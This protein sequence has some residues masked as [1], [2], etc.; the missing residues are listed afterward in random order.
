MELH[1]QAHILRNCVRDEMEADMQ[2]LPGK[3]LNKT[4]LS[5][6]LANHTSG[7]SESLLSVIHTV[8]SITAS[9]PQAAIVVC[10]NLILTLQD[11]TQIVYRK[12]TLNYTY[13]P[14]L[15]IQLHLNIILLCISMELN[16]IGCAIIGK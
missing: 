3:T 11:V 9:Y 15:S 16:L 1:L 7:G 4:F 10:L 14:P 6:T 5:K 12:N 8:T 13:T 2:D